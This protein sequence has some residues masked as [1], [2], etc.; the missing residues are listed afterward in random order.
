MSEE[1]TMKLT[2]LGHSCF[3]VESDGYSIVLDPYEDGFVPGLAPL[4][5]EANRVLCSHGHGDHNCVANVKV[6]EKEPAA[7]Q[8]QEIATYHDNVKGAKRGPN[9]IHIL[10]NGSVRIA[11]FGDLGCDLTEEQQKQ[12]SGLDAVLIPVGGFFTIDA[13]KA[14][15]IV[16]QICPRVIIPMHY[17]K[18]K[19]GLEPIGT[20]EA[21]TELFDPAQV[22][23]Y[24]GCEIEISKESKAQVAVLAL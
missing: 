24:P 13:K 19:V 4:R 23:E 20:V 17:R 15:E 3:K 16:D 18:G 9:T 8:V 6:T 10:D 14:K 7:I 1:K 21:F 12:L 22:V 2:W 5:A 11:H